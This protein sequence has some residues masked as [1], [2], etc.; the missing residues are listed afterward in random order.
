MLSYL[1]TS[2]TKQTNPLLFNS[3]SPK[4]SEYRRKIA[5]C[6]TRMSHE[7]LQS[8]V[9]ERILISLRNISIQASR[10]CMSPC[11][12]IFPASPEWLSAYGFLRLFHPNVTNSAIGS[13]TWVEKSS[14]PHDRVYHSNSQLY[15]LL[16]FIFAVKGTWPK[17]MKEGFILARY[18]WWLALRDNGR[19]RNTW[20]VAEV[21]DLDANWSV[22]TR[23]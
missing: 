2:S 4:I 12:L 19:Y 23:M 5:R 21:D 15:M 11:I 9:P 17:Q 14:E 20:G 3:A 1:R 18:R 8:L 16:M 10:V 13:Y 6:F 22:T 7:C